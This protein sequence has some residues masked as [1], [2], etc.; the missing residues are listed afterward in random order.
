ML[1]ADW[2]PWS[3]FFMLDYFSRVYLVGALCI[4]IL[5][6]AAFLRLMIQIRSRNR[7]GETFT[8]NAYPNLDGMHRSLCSLESFA[9]V[10]TSGCC[11]NQIFVVWFTYMAR[12][13]DAN[14]FFAL[15]EA[16]TVSQILIC[17][18][19]SLDALRRY[20]S[21]VLERNRPLLSV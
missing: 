21:A 7:N 15:K 12:V 14:P 18:I 9:M 4:V 2:G 11:A 3:L 17:A 16:W 20:A 1:A 19:V 10:L 13:T 5:G 8:E 6:Y